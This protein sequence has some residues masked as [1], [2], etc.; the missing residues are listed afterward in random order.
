MHGKTPLVFGLGLA[1]GTLALSP[2]VIAQQTPQTLE[3]VE[4]TGS[5]IKRSEAEGPAPLEIITRQEIQ[6]TGA[7]TLNELMRS[8]PSLDILDQGEL[9]SNSPIGSGTASFRMRG[10]DDTNLLVLLNGRRLPT[11]ALYDST[12]AGASVD[13]NMIPLAAIERV[14]ILKDGGSAIYGADAVAGVINIITRRDFRGGDVYANYGISSR[15]DGEEKR[16]GAVFGFGDL[17]QD[18]YNLMVTVDYFKRD[19]IYRKDRN[20]SKS[21]DYRRFPGGLDARSPFAP[22]GNYVDTSTF[23]LTGA[24]V[25]PCPPERYNEFCRFDFNASVL[26]AY[27]GADHLSTMAFGSLLAGGV[28]MSGELFF[29]QAENTFES[30]PVPDFFAVP[31]GTGFI[32]GRFMQGGPRETERDSRLFSTA[33]AAEGNVAAYEWKLELGHAESRVTNNDRNYYDERLWRPATLNGSIDPTVNTNDPAFV[34]SLKIRP[35]RKGKSDVEYVN[36]LLRGEAFNLPAGPMGFATG[37]QYR[38]QTLRDTPDPLSQQDL[39]VGSIQQAAVSAA[40]E[41]WSAF[42]EL[43]V[44]VLRN[45][46]AQLALRHDRYSD[47]DATSPK[48]AAKWNVVP[49]LSV[50]ASYAESFRS[51]ALKQRFGAR[52]QGA[53]TI[54]E[55]EQCD[56]LGIAPSSPCNVAAFQITGANPNLKPEKA[57]TYNLGLVFQPFARLSGALD[58]WWIYKKDDISTLTIPA[59]IENGFVGRDPNDGRYLIFTNL[60]NVAERAV[61]GVDFDVQY[62]QPSSLGIFTLRNAITYTDSN[63]TREAGQNWTEFANTYAQPMYRNVFRVTYERGAWSGQ[64]Q[65]RTTGGFWDTDQPHP[66]AT[67]TRKVGS[68]TEV[69]LSVRYAGMRN[70]RIE[71]GVLNMFDKEPPFSLTNA[72]DNQYSQLGFAELYTNR[73]RFFYVNVGYRFQ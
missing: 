36:T 17:D 68:F 28:K 2:A 65:A 32:A 43:N 6:R 45:V 56:Q 35:T 58:F 31:S 61:R 1:F 19:P 53:A 64:T 70:W 42:G 49:E 15:G 18:R 27:N 71:G 8:I 51:P 72:L 50:R 47:Y 63:R 25:Q 62:R 57:K 55:R 26:T 4:V 13:V 14:E 40:E 48:V 46:E 60:Q 11:N 33:L 9:V 52:E 7:T 67:G 59:A 29:S 3:R 34:E 38:K 10:L 21:A 69:D 30:H 73:G 23:E 37:I 5:A 44:P 54:T 24:S 22:E 66:V 39:V 20:L 16:T 12:G 41:V